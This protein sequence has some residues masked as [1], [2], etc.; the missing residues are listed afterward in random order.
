MIMHSYSYFNGLKTPSM[1]ITFPFLCVLIFL[2]KKS[3]TFA[4]YKSNIILFQILNS[5]KPDGTGEPFL[6]VVLNPRGES[7]LR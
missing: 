1:V 6:W 7:F 4:K 5:L 3:F 2:Q